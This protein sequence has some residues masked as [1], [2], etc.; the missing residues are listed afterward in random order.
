MELAKAQARGG[1]L[2]GATGLV[3]LLILS[4]VLSGASGLIYQVIWFRVLGLIFG[5]SVH[6]TSAVLAAFMAGLA[7]G[8]VVTGRFADRIKRPLLAYGIVEIG[9]GVFGLSSLWALELLQ[10]IYK[11]LALSVTDSVVVLSVIRFALAFLILLV[12]TTMMGATMP[13][14]V[15]SSLLRSG[16]LSRNV[17]LLYAAN[18]FGAVAGAFSSAF[19]LI[20][21]YGVTVTTAIA[22]GINMAVGVLWIGVSLAAP[23]ETEAAPPEVEVAPELHPSE[24]VSPATARLVLIVYGLSGAIALAYEVVWTRLLAGV[25]PSTVYAFAIMLCAILTGIAIGSWAVNGLIARR[26]NWLLRFAVLEVALGVAAVLSLTVIAQAYRAE[27]LVRGWL[28]WSAETLVVNEP[29]FM[30]TFALFCIGPTAF[31]MGV[32]FPV[33]TK[34]YASGFTEVGRRVGTIYGVNVLGALAGSLGGGLV[35]IPLLGA[36]RALW[37]LAI[38]NA[39]LGLI[40]L[41]ATRGRAPQRLGFAAASATLFGAI[42]VASPDVYQTLFS[43]DPQTTETIWFHEGQDANVR[44]ARDLDGNL[45]LFTNSAGQNNDSRAEAVFHYQLGLLGPLLHPNPKEVLVVG[46]GVGQTAGAASQHPGTHTTVVELLPGV[47]EAAPL[48]SHV[49]FN[50]HTNPDVTIVAADGRNYLLLAGQRF[51]VIESDP[52]WP[53]HAGA[54]NL[55]SADYY[56]LA[57]QAL[58]DDGIMV[59]WVD[60][61]LPEHAYRMMV[62]SFYEVFPEATMW[63][64]GTILVGAKGP[65]RLDYDAI[66]A[67]FQ[68]PRLRAVMEDLGIRGVNDVMREFVG[69]PDEVRAFLGPGPVVSDRYPIIEYINSV[70]S[71]TLGADL[72]WR[73][74]ASYIAARERSDDGIAFSEPS[75]ARL[76]RS[77]HATKLAEYVPSSGVAGRESEVAAALKALL[78]SRERVWFIPWWQNENDQFFERWLNG[79]AYHV[80]NRLIGNIRVHL[81]AS[82]RGEP[83]LQAAHFDFGDAIRIAG[84]AVDRRD[85]GAGDILRVA[86]QVEAIDDL[87]DDVKIAVRLIGSDGQIAASS[88]RLPRDAPTANWKVGTS[89]LDRIGILIPPGTPPGRY[90]V[91]LDV[92]RQADGT[93]LAPANPNAAG[94]RVV[95]AEVTILETNR[96]FPADAVEAASLSGATFGDAVRLAGY[97]LD[98]APRRPGDE[99]EAALFWQQLSDGG[100]RSLRLVVGNPANPVGVSELEVGRK[101]GRAGTISRQDGRVRVRPG[102]ERGRYDV[103]IIDRV[104]PDNREWLG[105]VDVVAP[106]VLPVPAAPDQPLGVRFGDSIVLEGISVRPASDGVAVTLVWRAEG[107]IPAN[108]VAFVH[109]LDERDAIVSQS[110]QPPAAGAAPTGGWLPGQR[111]GDLHRLSPSPAGRKL[112]IG[113]YDP[114]TGQRLMSSVGDMVVVPLS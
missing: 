31:L 47:I 59:Q 62:R 86:L 51:D 45:V 12:P 18:T 2:A 105:R 97:T 57:R 112:A 94:Q 20:G 78:E 113:L 114:R 85:L 69:R 26:G 71:G 80:S 44:V 58:K 36:Q 91:D 34:L 42:A 64:H 22:A 19:Y 79:N 33:A 48:F 60:A 53:T 52:I 76:F 96:P 111:V 37:A 32:T 5:V 35:L 38:G 46:L 50:L 89:I 8:S 66:E 24:R 9:I 49:N 55:Y 40:V 90:R 15:R 4:L 61:S 41:L 101:D 43:T 93:R 107:D 108:Y 99:I 82:A 88:D 16:S 11:A 39:V 95:L 92:Y 75:V 23:R 109:L 3:G 68:D 77:F 13:L 98:L 1:L 103:W 87:D 84:W 74:V 106:T 30:L 100:T 21:L 7:V 70:P 25:F 81:Y 65:L 63:Y 54:A 17:S 56:R 72:R 14:V 6:A 110:D 27:R 10:P 29:W 83:A 67:K 28:G 102:A 73:R 104:N